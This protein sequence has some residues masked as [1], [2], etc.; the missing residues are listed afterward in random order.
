MHYRWKGEVR[1]ISHYTST[2][3]LILLQRRTYDVYG[4]LHDLFWFYMGLVG[5]REVDKHFSNEH[6]VSLAYPDFG[7]VG[8]VLSTRLFLVL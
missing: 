1:S 4:L 6:A 3:K 8:V 5:I 2:G 7:E